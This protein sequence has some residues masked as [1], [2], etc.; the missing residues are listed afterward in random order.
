VSHPLLS[1]AVVGEVAV[2]RTYDTIRL[3]AGLYGSFGPGWNGSFETLVGADILEERG[4][5]SAEV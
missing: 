2:S 3:T 5:G 4:N 1:E